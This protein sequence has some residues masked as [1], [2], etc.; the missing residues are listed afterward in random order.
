[1]PKLNK[2][3]TLIELLVVI[4]IIAIL[5]GAGSVS[6]TKA[7]VKGRDSRRK[8]DL[9]AVQQAA[10]LY[11]QAN[12]KYPSSSSGQI[13]CNVGGDVT[14]ITWGGTF[15]CNSTVYMQKL[16][17]D[18]TLQANGYYYSNPSTN[19]YIFSTNLE[20]TADSDLSSLSCTPQ[21]GRNY[22]VTNP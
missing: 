18:P 22:C 14:V 8:V 9:K 16:P 1:M 17:K 19:T 3:F 4:T 10:E 2:G 15:T 7:Q 5:I 21:S 6:W 12:G 11:Y 20:N 13:Q